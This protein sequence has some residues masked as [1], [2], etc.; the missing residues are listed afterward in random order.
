MIICKFGEL[1]ISEDSLFQYSIIII[2]CER[3]NRSNL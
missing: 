3:Q 1:A 2:L